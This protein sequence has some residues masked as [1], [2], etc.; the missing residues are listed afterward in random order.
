VD[1]EN[2]TVEYRQWTFTRGRLAAVR[3]SLMTLMS[4][5]LFV[6]DVKRSNK[7]G[8]RIRKSFA[9]R[10]ASSQN[11]L[12]VADTTEGSGSESFSRSRGRQYG[13][14]SGYCWM[15]LKSARTVRFLMCAREW[16]SMALSSC[17]KSRAKSGVAKCDMPL[18]A[19]VTS[20]GLDDKSWHQGQSE[21]LNRSAAGI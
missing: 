14:A 21:K 20:A 19:R 10:R 6:E 2:R 15:I 9:F 12:T 18:R 3:T 8:A 17:V 13:R 11:R 7:I 16:F 1:I 4:I 5:Q